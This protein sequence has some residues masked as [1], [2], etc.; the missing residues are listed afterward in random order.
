MLMTPDP[1]PLTMSPV[2]SL[3][4]L[5][6]RRHRVVVSFR[7]LGYLTI[8]N[9]KPMQVKANGDYL[10]ANV[11]CANLATAGSGDVLT[12]LVTAL[13]AQGWP[14]NAAL[15]AAVHLHGL[16]ADRLVAQGRGAVGI[17]AGEL[18]DSA[19]HCYNEWLAAHAE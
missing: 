3:A 11:S 1:D 16:A 14:A 17:A 8:G 2:C 19:R 10:A 4:T 6:V 13:L 12:G 18:I 9:F 5:Q 15:L 7:Y